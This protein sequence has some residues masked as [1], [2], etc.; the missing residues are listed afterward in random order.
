MSDE[1]SVD[2]KES[3]FCKRF[4]Q[5]AIDNIAYKIE[6]AKASVTQQRALLKKTWVAIREYRRNIRKLRESLTSPEKMTAKLE[7]QVSEAG[8]IYRKTR[9]GV[10]YLAMKIDAKVGAISFKGETR[11]YSN[12]KLKWAGGPKDPKTGVMLVGPN[13]PPHYYVR[14]TGSTNVKYPAEN[15]ICLGTA[16][17]PVNTHL[18]TGNLLMA[19]TILRQTMETPPSIEPRPYNPVDVFVCLVRCQGKVGKMTQLGTATEPCENIYSQAQQPS[20]PKC[21][22]RSGS[23]I[24]DESI[25]KED[26]SQKPQQLQREVCQYGCPGPISRYRYTVAGNF[27]PV[28]QICEQTLD[29]RG[30]LRPIDI[31]MPQVEWINL[32]I[33]GLE[34]QAQ[35]V[36]IEAQAPQVEEAEPPVCIF[37]C[38]VGPF[39]ARAER[40]D[41]VGPMIT[42][43][44]TCANNLMYCAECRTYMHVEDSVGGPNGSI[45]EGCRE[46]YTS[47]TCCDGLSDPDDMMYSERLDGYFCDN[48][49]LIQYALVD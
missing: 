20:C 27:I 35:E 10:E 26:T 29:R 24:F 21:G 18:R 3:D 12:G 16:K 34:V 37:G 45:C 6:L 2:L 19:M 36:A 30:E 31:P 5:T 15:D 49:C 13:C 4:A 48:N 25:G 22:S 7:Q 47:C 42:V 39:F 43:C 14:Q 28:C 32:G 38:T 23:G 8:L 46:N 33:Q 11:L 41:Q 17:E 9:S 1:D 44:E 40:R